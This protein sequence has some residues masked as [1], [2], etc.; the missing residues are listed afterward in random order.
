MCCAVLICGVPSLLQALAGA[1]GGL[2]LLYSLRRKSL[3]S[4]KQMNAFLMGFYDRIE[5]ENLGAFSE[6]PVLFGLG[7]G[8]FNASLLRK[9]RLKHTPEGSAIKTIKLSALY[10][11]KTNSR[12]V[13]YDYENWPKRVKTKTWDELIGLGLTEGQICGATGGRPDRNKQWFLRVETESQDSQK[14]LVARY[15]R[16]RSVYKRNPA[17]R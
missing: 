2:S 6:F 17:C 4:D 15:T 14:L 9:L 3:P 16:G 10:G 7:A 11:S 12:D 1:L 13:Y 5:A 8:Y